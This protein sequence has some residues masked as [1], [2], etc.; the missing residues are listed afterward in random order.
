MFLLILSDTPQG[1]TRPQQLQGG[2][3]GPRQSFQDHVCTTQLVSGKGV[4][5]GWGETTHG[6]CNLVYSIP[7]QD[8]T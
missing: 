8:V 7:F 6:S 3:D 1:W 4:Y 5:E 2:W